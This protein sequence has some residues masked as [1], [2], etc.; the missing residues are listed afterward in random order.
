MTVISRAGIP[1]R[2][3]MEI[4]ATAS[5]GA[6]SAPSASAA[7]QG[8]WGTTKWATTATAATVNS[9]EA[10]RQQQDGAGVGPEPDQARLHRRA[11]EQRRQH[12]DEHHLGVEREHRHPGH[13]GH[14]E[15]EEDE[16][17]GR[18]DAGAPREQ[19]GEA[20][21]GDDQQDRT[22]SFHVRRSSTCAPGSEDWR[23]DSRCAPSS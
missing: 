8:S 16:E 9:S 2:R 7:A 3:P 21:R 6:T 19:P 22:V 10:H 1:T 15:P 23:T 17:H 12:Q 5:G 18:G 4:A 11:V 14:R 20:D 13:R